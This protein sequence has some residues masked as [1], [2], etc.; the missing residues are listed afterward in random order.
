MNPMNAHRRERT[1]Q[2]LSASKT[3]ARIDLKF[4]AIE[5]PSGGVVG[6]SGSK[7]IRRGTSG[8]PS[9]RAISHE[10]RTMTWLSH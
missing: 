9:L 4:N 8:G 3:L 7:E 5:E 2:W 10:R 6:F 1:L